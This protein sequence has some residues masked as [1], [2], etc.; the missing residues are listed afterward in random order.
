MLR[1]PT[2]HRLGAWLERFQ[3]HAGRPDPAVMP[4]PRPS[5]DDVMPPP[6]FASAVPRSEPSLTPVTLAIPGLDAVPEPEQ[7]AA[8]APAPRDPQLEQHHEQGLRLVADYRW[9]QAQRELERAARA[10]PHGPAAMDLASVREVRRQLRVLRK[11]PR[12]VPAHLTLGRAYFELGL[13]ADAE[14]IFRRVLTLAPQEPAAPYFLALEYAFCGVWP[15]AEEHYA[16]A[17]ALAP[18]L[19]PFADWLDAHGATRGGDAARHQLRSAG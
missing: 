6:G 3:G 10:T 14:A 13:G 15:V 5:G 11:W 4:V 8:P 9:S 12:D 16:Q 18:D 19:P 17:R 1:R 2:L 7:A